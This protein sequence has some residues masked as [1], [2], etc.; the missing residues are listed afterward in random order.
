M[1][2][3]F[4]FAIA[5]FAA[6][7]VMVSCEKDEPKDPNGGG[8]GNEDDPTK[9]E[10]LA[11]PSN[12][13]GT[14][15]GDDLTIT[16]D[17]VENAVSYSYVVDNSEPATV[18]EPSVTL[19]VEALGYGDHTIFVTALPEDGSEQ[20]TASDEA[21][22]KFSLSEPVPMPDEYADY[23]GTWT[24]T[25]TKTLVAA[26][27]Q[28]ESDRIDETQ[29]TIEN[30]SIAWSETEGALLMTGFTAFET[31]LES[32]IPAYIVPDEKGVLNIA[33]VQLNF[34]LGELDPNFSGYMTTWCPMYMTEEGLGVAFSQGG[35]IPAYALTMS[36]DG[37]TITADGVDLQFSDGSTQTVEAYDLV[38]L[39]S[40]YYT[41]LNA[42]SPAGTFTFTKTGNNA[43]AP[44]TSVSPLLPVT[45]TLTSNALSSMMA[46]PIA[47]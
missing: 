5:A 12:F 4:Y 31:V 30:V 46:S 25:T 14:V 10:K 44:A 23:V 24:V 34:D 36:E 21:S 33:G 43:P 32:S 37:N 26:T 2:R 39:S 8:N 40:Q 18:T 42:N 27:A 13:D 28:G 38:G 29:M 19:S 20:Y 47:R 7:A 15:N 9:T 6:T 45:M 17:A 41:L 22:F 3:I 35:M 11:A 16:W 1:K